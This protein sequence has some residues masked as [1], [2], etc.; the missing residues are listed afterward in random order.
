MNLADLSDLIVEQLDGH[1]RSPTQEHLRDDK[2][3]V[4]ACGM[5]VAHGEWNRHVTNAII[6]AIMRTNAFGTN[7]SQ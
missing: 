5:E 3:Y 4:C 2:V 1:H 6:A 7:E